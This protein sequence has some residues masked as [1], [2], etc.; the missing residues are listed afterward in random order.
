MTIN[1]RDFLKNS[2]MGV[3]VSFLAPSVFSETLFGQATTSPKTLVVLQLA[4]GNDTVNTFIPYGDAQYRA[5][6]PALAIADNT[7]LKI[8]NRMGLHPS[9]A[10]LA[11]LYESGKFTFVNNVGFATL[12]RSHFRCQDVWQTGDDSYGQ[13]QRGVLGWVGRYADIYLKDSQSSLTTL[14]IGSRIPLGMWADDVI[15]AVVGD[16]ASYDVTTDSRY[17]DDRTPFVNTLRQIYGIDRATETLDVIRENGNDMFSSV[18]LLKTIPPPST[19]TAYPDSALARGFKLIAQTIAGNVGTQAVWITTGGFDTHS[20]QLNTHSN[21]LKDVGD[22]LAAFY[23][24]LVARG[25]SDRVVVVAWS[26]FGRRV[27]ENASAGTDHG[28]AGTVFLLGD[29]VNGRQFYGDVPNL[30]DLDAGDLKTQIDFRSVYWTLI[31]DFLG[32]DPE[33]VLNGRYENVGFIKKASVLPG[34]RRPVGRP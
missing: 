32:K 1:R 5:M 26:E 10:K 12:D 34:R 17:P 11:P 6:R 20:T 29:S 33:P 13:S 31:Q 3:T 27:S 24:D 15:P 28:K 23:D 8:D 18:D 14:A 4:G 25:I 9:L 19:S 2:A 30:N 21:L 22:S 16:A 7:I